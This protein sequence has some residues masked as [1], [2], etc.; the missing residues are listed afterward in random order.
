MAEEARDEES[1]EE[2]PQ[3]IISEYI[4]FLFR[5]NVLVVALKFIWTGWWVTALITFHFIEMAVLLGAGVLIWFVVNDA[6]NWQ[7][8]F[9]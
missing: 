6:E 8:E 5:G 4:D 1:F 9:E 2:E 3:G 7:V